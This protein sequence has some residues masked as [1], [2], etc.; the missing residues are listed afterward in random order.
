MVKQV[1]P[2][3]K[4]T[5]T[6]PSFL[7]V[8]AGNDIPEYLRGTKDSVDPD[9]YKEGLRT[10][11]ISLIQRQ[12]PEVI[13]SKPEYIEGAQ[14]GQFSFKGAAYDSL[15]VIPLDMEL[16]YVVWPN[17]KGPRKEAARL[18]SF[19]DESQAYQAILDAKENPA[20]WNIITTHYHAVAVVNQETG[21]IEDG[22]ALISMYSTNIDVSAEWNADIARRGVARQAQA[23]RLGSA[24]ISHKGEVWSK[25]T[26]EFIG[27]LPES[28]YKQAL[29]IMHDA[30]K[31]LP[32]PTATAS[33]QQLEAKYA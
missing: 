8:Q 20:D 22:N 24:E 30:K 3:S 33:E 16:A 13:R 2:E 29:G 18:G 19:K 6:L 31:R 23:F 7:Q 5:A 25:F 27:L 21:L 11:Y 14:A 10:P 12:S 4:N 32:T 17:R 9:K 1:S 26:F 15:I 28:E